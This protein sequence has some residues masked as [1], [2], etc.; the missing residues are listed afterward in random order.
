MDQKYIIRDLRNKDNLKKSSFSGYKK[1]DVLSEFIKACD[2]L[3]L[4]KALFWITEIHCSFYMED[5]FEKIFNYISTKIH[6]NSYELPIVVWNHYLYLKGVE[7]DSNN[8]KVR[9]SIYEIVALI[10]QCDRQRVLPKKKTIKDTDFNIQKLYS[11]VL[12]NTN[13]VPANIIKSKDPKIVSI[14]FNELS[15]CV[16]KHDDLQGKMQDKKEKEREFYMDKAIYWICWIHKW[17]TIQK[18][19]GGLANCAYR[20]VT[21]IVKEECNDIVWICWAV[22]LAECKRRNDRDLS[23]QVSSLYNMYKYNFTRAKKSSKMPMIIHC[24]SLLILDDMVVT[25]TL[26]SNPYIIQAIMKCNIFYEQIKKY[27]CKEPIPEIMVEN[28]FNV[29]KQPSKQKKKKESKTKQTDESIKKFDFMMGIDIR[30][31]LN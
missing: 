23:N 5:I 26:L 31:Q 16:T 2:D 15:Y 8:Q 11:C 7:F 29:E 24:C 19:K 22:I 14:V 6:L 17:D 30:R 27:E 13:H 25:H 1:I 4:E 12:C 20:N 21:G 18:K 9:N 3:N 28:I 10:I